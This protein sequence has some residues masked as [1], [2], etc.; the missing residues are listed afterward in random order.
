MGRR[1]KEGREG[2]GPKGTNTNGHNLDDMKD[3]IIEHKNYPSFQLI[4]TEQAP[5]HAPVTNR[6]TRDRFEAQSTKWLGGRET[7]FN[8]VYTCEGVSI[9]TENS[10]MNEIASPLRTVA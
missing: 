1:V 8:N 9:N 5:E 6:N 10:G 2:N 4:Y 3:S 7:I